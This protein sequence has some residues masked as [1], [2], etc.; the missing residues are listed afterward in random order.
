V[1]EHV[2]E[3]CRRFYSVGE[4]EPEGVGGPTH[5]EE[6]DVLMAAIDDLAVIA[7]GRGASSG[8]GPWS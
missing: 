3:P 8:F 1:N 4:H 6:V 2:H 7:S 5:L